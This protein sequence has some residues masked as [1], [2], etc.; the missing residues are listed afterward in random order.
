M[1]IS[2]EKIKEM[3]ELRNKCSDFIKNTTFPI[4]K[5]HSDDIEKY[6]DRFI[7]FPAS[8]SIASI[9]FTP[10]SCVKNPALA[11]IGMI[12]ILVSLMVALNIFRVSIR[13]DKLFIKN[14]EKIEEPMLQFG[15]K[16]TIFSMDDENLSKEKELLMSHEDLIKKYEENPVAENIVDVDFVYNQINLSFYMLSTGVIISVLSML[17]FC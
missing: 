14:I 7:K 3:Q 1:T 2:I 10:L 9:I 13:N 16:L 8:A 6:L 17:S 5:Q 4:K 12:F 11:F 15:K